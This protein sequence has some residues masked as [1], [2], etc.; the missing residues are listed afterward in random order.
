ME[1]LKPWPSLP[2]SAGGVLDDILWLGKKMGYG[3]AR[4][5][6]GPLTIVEMLLVPSSLAGPED[7]ELLHPCFITKQTVSS[8]RSADQWFDNC[9]RCCDWL[10]EPLIKNPRSA[11][12]CQREN[13][14]S[15]CNRDCGTRRSPWDKGGVLGP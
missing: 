4:A 7:D 8:C 10:F 6:E 14:R 13:S 3:V 1:P 11:R 9:V 12:E 2:T 5:V 15:Q